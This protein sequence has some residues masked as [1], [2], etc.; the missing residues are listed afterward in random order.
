MNL[1]KKWWSR[2]TIKIKVNIK[3]IFLSFNLFKW[4]IQTGK[5]WEY[6]IYILHAKKSNIYF[7]L[8]FDKLQKYIVNP[9]KREHNVIKKNPLKEVK[10][11]HNGVNSI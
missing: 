2:E 7:D 6:T 4:K 10:K 9:R 3:Y 5:N 1:K 11:D 8:Y